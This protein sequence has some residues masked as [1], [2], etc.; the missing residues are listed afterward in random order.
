[1]LTTTLVFVTRTTLRFCVWCLNCY[2]LKS[3]AFSLSAFIRKL[4]LLF[5]RI[6]R[7]HFSFS[8]RKMIYWCLLLVDVGFSLPTNCN[9][10]GGGRW[11]QASEWSFRTNI[12]LCAQNVLTCMYELTGAHATVRAAHKLWD[13]WTRLN[14]QF[15]RLLLLTFC[16]LSGLRAAA[17]RLEKNQ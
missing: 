13:C 2:W 7:F 8:K 6:I 17:K 15:A 1:M 14:R 16:Y 4:F 12:G 3:F 5:N 11:E 9:R 10:G